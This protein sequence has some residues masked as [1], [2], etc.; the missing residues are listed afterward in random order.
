MRAIL[1]AYH[2]LPPNR[3]AVP[4][5]AVLHA[6]RHSVNACRI[7]GLAR[8]S[9]TGRKTE[10]ACSRSKISTP[11]LFKGRADPHPPLL[12]ETASVPG[13]YG[14]L[15]PTVLDSRQAEVPGKMRPSPVTLKLAMALPLIGAT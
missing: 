6:A 2:G 12:S 13:S 14:A 10:G 15:F 11:L 8:S 5:A 7:A 1:D 3:G 9:A 4:L